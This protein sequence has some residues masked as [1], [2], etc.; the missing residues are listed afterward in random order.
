[1]QPGDEGVVGT[2]AETDPAFAYDTRN[3]CSPYRPFSVLGE[4]L[5]RAGVT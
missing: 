5:R 1:M 4:F 3:T 2:R